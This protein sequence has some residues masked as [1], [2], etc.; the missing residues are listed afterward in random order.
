ME[1]TE[2]IR[3]GIITEKSVKLQSTTASQQR[4]VQRGWKTEDELTHQYVFEV[5][6]HANKIMIRKAVEELFPEVT[7]LAVNTMRMPGK[8][9]TLRTRRGVKHSEAREW[10][11][12]IVTVRANEVITQL[13]A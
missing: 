2:I 13:Q 10:K 5:H 8:S 9:R 6:L 3:R 1:A 7:V 12:A 4:A 11:K